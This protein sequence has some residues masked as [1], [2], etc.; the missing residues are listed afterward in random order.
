[1]AERRA[2][3]TLQNMSCWNRNVGHPLKRLIVR[4]PPP[5]PLWAGSLNGQ[6]LNHRS[7]TSIHTPETVA[8]SFPQ[9][10]TLDAKPE[11][12]GLLDPC[13]A[14][15]LCVACKPLGASQFSL[16]FLGCLCSCEPRCGPRQARGIEM[17]DGGGCGREGG[18][19][20]AACR[21]PGRAGSFGHRP[22]SPHLLLSLQ[23]RVNCV[24]CTPG[25]WYTPRKT[26]PEG[27]VL[28]KWVG[29]QGYWGLSPR[30]QQA[31]PSPFTSVAVALP[32]PR[33]S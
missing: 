3:N 12:T 18:A 1:M 17:E 9:S 7:S 26:G 15:G 6:A 5:R 24:P 19:A 30:S 2:C 29:V 4:D 16:F 31:D 23:V 27:L 14:R 32:L 10:S 22:P 13:P 33:V 21:T 11:V 25:P 8:K 20:K 28:R